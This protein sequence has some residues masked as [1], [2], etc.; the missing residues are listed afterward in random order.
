MSG[1]TIA[2]TLPEAVYER[3]RETAEVSSL[4]VQQVLAQSIA[5]SLPELEDDLPP[6]IRSELAALSLRSDTELRSIANSRMDQDKQIRLEDLA[7]L[8]EHRALTEAEQSELARLMDEA[9]RVMI[10]KAEAYRL[11]A[12]RGHAVFDTIDSSLD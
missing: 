1:R 8:L 12:R 6:E 7:E 11:L 5:L 2:V 9:E 4:S 10:R 3:A